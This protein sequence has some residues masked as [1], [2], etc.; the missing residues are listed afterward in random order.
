MAP[1]LICHRYYPGQQQ[2]QRFVFLA[3]TP[4][5]VPEPN[6]ALATRECSSK[7]QPRLFSVFPQARHT[8]L[9]GKSHSRLLPYRRPSQAV[10]KSH[11]TPHLPKPP[12]RAIKSSG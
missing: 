2:I 6:I 5:F 11:I 12:V 8:E 9:G 3:N 10:S 4:W 7:P 1:M